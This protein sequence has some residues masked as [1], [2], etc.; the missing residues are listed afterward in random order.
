MSSSSTSDLAA[1][2]FAWRLANALA[3]ASPYL[4]AGSLYLALY[5]TRP[6]AHPSTDFAASALPASGNGSTVVADA[7]APATPPQNQPNSAASPQTPAEPAPQPA[8]QLTP[9]NQPQPAPSARAKKT[10]PPAPT[11]APPPATP[12]S[13]PT[14]AAASASTPAPTPPIHVDPALAG[15]MKLSGPPPTY[16][17][18]AQAARMQGTVL[19]SVTI[20]PDGSVRDVSGISGPPL[21][22]AAAVTAV[23]SWRYRPW[24][25]Y[26][27]PVPFDTQVSIG[28]TIKQAA[29]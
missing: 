24:L 10:T 15:T 11:P 25:I 17:A 7:D 27:K 14:S 19:L 2:S 22:Q 9:Q 18:I 12:P 1:T 20:A 16:P 26:G 28:F 8:S 4:L 3:I 6:P 5:L 23:R 29:Q 21:L 13:A